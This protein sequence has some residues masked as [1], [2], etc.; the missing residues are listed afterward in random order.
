MEDTFDCLD[1]AHSVGIPVTELPCRNLESSQPWDEQK[2]IDVV[3]LNEVQTIVALPAF[4]ESYAPF[5]ET[6][7]YLRSDSNFTKET[8]PMVTTAT[9]LL[10]RR[11]EYFTLSPQ[12]WLKNA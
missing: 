2:G 11:K 6:K 9:K 8:K 4:L 3:G 5:F 1:M 12:S 10:R 7:K